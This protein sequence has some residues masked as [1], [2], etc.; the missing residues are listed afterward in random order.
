M[1][2]LLTRLNRKGIILS[3]YFGTLVF[4]FYL[5]L[6]LPLSL[7]IL[8][9]MSTE[10]FRKIENKYGDGASHRTPINQG[11]RGVLKRR[12]KLFLLRAKF[13][14]LLGDKLV[15]FAVDYP[16]VVGDYFV[17]LFVLAVR[18]HL[19]DVLVTAVKFTQGFYHSNLQKR[20]RAI[21]PK[22]LLPG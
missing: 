5:R 11:I 1:E 22:A 3:C 12:V 6:S 2:K 18:H 21:K 17:L 15:Q 10:I 14:P 9:A 8:S 16:Q 7:T 13:F 4:H 20:S 19:S